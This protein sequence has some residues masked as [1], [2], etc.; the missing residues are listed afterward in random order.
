MDP[1]LSCPTCDE[2][3]EVHGEDTF[4]CPEDHHYSVVG[5]ALT[6]NIAALRAIWLAI[7]ALEDDAASLSYMAKKYGN[8]FGLSAEAR[9]G[10]A[11][12][13]LDAAAMLRGHAQ[14]A[15]SRLD[16]LPTELPAARGAGHQGAQG[17]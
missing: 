4:R 7:R 12:A 1:N 2:D 3:L 5:L 13:A 16:A 14:R 6:A 10:E 15:Q 17:G 11:D 8:E 9:Q